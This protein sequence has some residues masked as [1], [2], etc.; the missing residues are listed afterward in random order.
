MQTLPLLEGQIM[1][2][3]EP[4]LSN[5]DAVELTQWRRD[6]HRRPELSGEEVE[7]AQ[8]VVV[9]MQ[10]A[11]ADRILTGLGGHGVAAIFDGRGD[12]PSVMLRCEL[13]GLP[14]EELGTPEWQSQSPGKGHLCGH[15]GH[16]AILA[17]VAR[18]LGRN[19]PARGRVILMFQPAEEDGAGAAKVIDDPQFD[20][21]T[22]DYALSLHNMPAVPL[23]HALLAQGP[24]NCASRGMKI[25]LTGRTSHAS[26]PENGVSPAGALATLIPLLAGLG[27]GGDASDPDFSLVTITHAR[28]GEP[29]FGIAPGE[30]ELWATLRTQ[31]DDRMARM[32]AAAEHAVAQA[33]EAAGLSHDISYHAIFHH[34]ENHPEATA[35]LSRALTAEGLVIET[36]GLPMRASEDFGRFGGCAKSAMFLLGAGDRVASLHNP[37]Y[38]FPDELIVPGARVFIRV[39]RDLLW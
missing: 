8:A 3:A 33:A 27:Q 4:V 22:P 38:D 20:Q 5:S 6:L 36:A 12:G 26:Q 11:G 7:T 28:L 39:L 16:M 13:D 21:I 31:K 15:D 30:A 14:I 17:G 32:V 18:W 24:F 19:R 25:V 2:Q 35:I 37:D 9:A 34:C 10:A 23:G 1:T 29:A